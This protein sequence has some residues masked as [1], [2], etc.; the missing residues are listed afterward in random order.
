LYVRSMVLEST[1][2]PNQEHLLQKFAEMVSTMTA[3]AK[4]TKAAPLPLVKLDKQEAAIVVLMAQQEKAFVKQ[5]HKLAT[6]VNGAIALEKSDQ[7]LN[8]AMAKTTT[9]MAK[10]MIH[11]HSWENLVQV[12]KASVKNQENSFVKPMVQASLV[13][14]NQDSP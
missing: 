4:P 8:Y 9:V 1:A 6:K 13:I 5:E 10:S 11:T 12:V 2:L 3:M 14:K 7:V